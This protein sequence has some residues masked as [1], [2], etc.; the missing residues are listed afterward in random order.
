MKPTVMKKLSLRTPKVSKITP[1]KDRCIQIHAKIAS[2]QHLIKQAEKKSINNSAWRALLNSTIHAMNEALR[3]LEKRL[4]LIQAELKE[5]LVFGLFFIVS[6]SF[7]VS[8]CANLKETGKQVWGSSIAHLERARANGKSSEFALSL[9]E[10]FSKIDKIL[11]SMGAAVYL[12]D[13][14]KGYLAAMNF[15]GHVDTTQVGIFFTMI[16][17]RLTRV[18]VAS[19]SPDLVSEVS[20]VLFAELKEKVS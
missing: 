18:E 13:K 11:E 8:G 3:D 6:A 10:S 15:K 12:K 9:D 2:L 4:D 16:E 1:L 20:S 14:D 17:E 5:F 19:M 7:F